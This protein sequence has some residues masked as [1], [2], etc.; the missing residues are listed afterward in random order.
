MGS[1][2]S[3]PGI[4]SLVGIQFLMQVFEVWERGKGEQEENDKM[5][6]KKKDRKKKKETCKRR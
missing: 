3:G 4:S 1:S 2:G 5:K 6:R